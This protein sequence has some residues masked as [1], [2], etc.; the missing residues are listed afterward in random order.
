M[1]ELLQYRTWC[2]SEDFFNAVAPTFY[3]WLATGHGIDRF[4]N[5]KKVEEYIPEL[6]ALLTRNENEGHTAVNETPDFKMS[7]SF[8]QSVGLPV[9]EANNLRI[10]VV[11]MVGVLTKYGNLCAYGMQ[12]YQAMITRANNSPNIDGIL[13]KVDSPGGTTDGTM[14]LATVVKDSPKMVGTFIDGL[15][16]SAMYWISSQGKGPMVA[17]KYNNNTIG[18]IGT[19]GVYEN[20]SEKLAKEGRQVKIIRAKQS[21]KKISANPI[22]PLTP[23]AEAEIQSQADAIN[24]VFINY[25]KSARPGVAEEVFQAGTYDNLRA[26]NAGLISGVGTMQTAINKM[27]EAIKEDR[28]KSKGT[29]GDSPNANTEMKFPK[30]SSLFG[31]SAK[32]ANA[33]QSAEQEGL[34]ADQASMEAAE[35]KLAE[36]EADNLK[37]KSE[38]EAAEAKAT[39]LEAT[40]AE[41]AAQITALEGE[42]T[43]LSN[44]V[45]E[46]KAK[47]TGTATT[48]IPGKAEDTQHADPQTVTKSKF[49][50]TADD[51]SDAYVNAM[52]PQPS[53]Q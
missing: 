38:K 41:Q 28:K 32:E 12:D 29:S 7:I 46:L 23:E 45:A 19:Y 34:V 48:V 18:S 49:R 44:Q 47:P 50:T 4:V 25:V 2:I 37:L 53:K 35:G 43:T 8:D 24:D 10:A 13:L 11:P 15:N 31:K 30:I 36:M 14:E 6:A 16:C 40:V 21:T 9:V 1:F 39:A 33:A 26:K 22:E 51:E 3:Q 20:I 52:Y 5:K 42:K 27:V 17:N